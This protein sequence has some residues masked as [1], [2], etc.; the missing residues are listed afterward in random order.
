MGLGGGLLVPT[1]LR[2]YWSRF[3]GG[4]FAIGTFVGLVA[5]ILHKQIW[6]ALANSFNV[7]ELND[8][9]MFTMLL[10]IGLI[11][12]IIGTYITKPTDRK[13]TEHF[14][15]TTDLEGIDYIGLTTSEIK[16]LKILYENDYKARLNVIASR[17][18]LNPSNVS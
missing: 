6:A 10:I 18:G 4:G 16:Y 17:I 13:V 1:V 3:N 5:A 9:K 2:L 15:K 14:Y 8:W 11:A 7:G 12:S